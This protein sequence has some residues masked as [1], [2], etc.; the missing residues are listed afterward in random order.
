VGVFVARVSKGRTIREFLATALLVPTLGSFIWFAALGGAGL[1]TM[2]NGGGAVA[3]MVRDNEALAL[4]AVLDTLPFTK[5]SWALATLL[6]IVFFVTSSDSGSFVDDMVTSGGHPNPPRLQRVFWAVAE[7]TVAAVLLY[8]GGL[9]ALRSASLATGLPIAVF[10]LVAAVG[11]LRA[12]RVELSSEGVPDAAD[13][14][15]DD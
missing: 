5:L 15:P 13:M 1:D 10:L 6:V 7:G 14:E 9:T 12:L 11:L 3:D 2:A 4:F 8:A